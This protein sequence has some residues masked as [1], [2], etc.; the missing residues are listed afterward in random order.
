MQHFTASWEFSEKKKKI[1]H[2]E[3]LLK[4]EQLCIVTHQLLDLSPSSDRCDFSCD[5]NYLEPFMTQRL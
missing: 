5:L 3:D 2:G 4:L 1:D